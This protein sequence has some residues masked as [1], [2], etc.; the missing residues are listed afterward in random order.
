VQSWDAQRAG[1][2]LSLNKFAAWLPEEYSS[3]MLVSAQL[4]LPGRL[5]AVVLGC[6]A[7]VDSLVLCESCG[8]P[9]GLP[10]AG[11]RSLP[12]FIRILPPPELRHALSIKG[13]LRPACALRAPRTPRRAPPQTYKKSG[14]RHAS[15]GTYQRVLSDEQLPA[16]VDW[17][18]TPADGLVKD[19]ATCGSCWVRRRCSLGRRRLLPARGG[20]GPRLRRAIVPLAHA[21]ADADATPAGRPAQAFAAVGAMQGAWYLATGEQLSL[22]EQ[23]LVDCRCDGPAWPQPEPLASPPPLPRVLLRLLLPARPKR[24]SRGMRAGAACSLALT[25]RPLPRPRSWD[26]GNNGCG[27]GEMEPAIQ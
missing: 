20:A 12:L 13:M 18:G 8:S 7:A 10:D 15:L 22:S 26:Y 6:R 24:F 5:A 25:S 11:N 2:S 27:G 16:S 17:R 14:R 3:L 21:D 19:Q 9:M 4:A 23:Q 1:F